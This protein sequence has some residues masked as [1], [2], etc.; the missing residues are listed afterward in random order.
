MDFNKLGLVVLSLMFMLMLIA[1]VSAFEFDNV[2]SYD[3]V[4]RQVKITNAFGLGD[5][6]GMARLNTPLNV[7]SKQVIK[8]LQS[9]IFGLIKIIMMP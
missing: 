8:K 3:P 7:L 5:E 9:L 6:I 2:K 4:T 1:P